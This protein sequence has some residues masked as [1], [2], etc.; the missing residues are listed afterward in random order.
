MTG[1]SLVRSASDQVF[2]HAL[3]DVVRA[4]LAAQEGSAS[5]SPITQYTHYGAATCCK[6]LSYLSGL[7]PK[8][9]NAN[10]SVSPVSPLATSFA[11]IRIS[12]MDGPAIACGSSCCSSPRPPEAQ[13]PIPQAES[14]KVLKSSARGR[15]SL[16]AARS[17]RDRVFWMKRVEAW[18]AKA[19]EDVALISGCKQ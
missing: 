10:A 12:G 16:N 17:S 18:T 9:W 3:V 13:L 4:A 1:S 2:A 7:R 6:R 14:R 11:V 15:L 5:I 19:L 8:F